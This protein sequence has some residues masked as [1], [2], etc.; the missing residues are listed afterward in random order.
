MSDSNQKQGVQAP[1]RH[2]V[3]VYIEDTDVGGVVYYAN[4]LKYLERAR[5]ELFRSIGCEFRESF[6][7]LTS[8]VVHSLS[9]KYLK[10]ARLDDLLIVSTQVTKLGKTYLEFQQAIKNENE[11]M[12]IDA[13]VKVACVNMKT[14]KPSRLPD[15]IVRS[16][17]PIKS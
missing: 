1:F 11:E 8:F 12:L 2:E 6:E 5:T 17:G 3:R 13:F 14:E 15:F 7:Q 16:L 4:Y 9:I 10:S